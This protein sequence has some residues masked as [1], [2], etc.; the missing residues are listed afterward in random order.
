MVKP[1]QASP[2][3]FKILYT[4]QVKWC[5]KDLCSNQKGLKPNPKRSVWRTFSGQLTVM[6]VI[7][8]S[9]FSLTV[10]RENRTA[11]MSKWVNIDVVTSIAPKTPLCVLPSPSVRQKEDICSS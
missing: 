9:P 6:D 11:A 4:L 2:T 8:A 3:P 10:Q 5:Q 7:G 1:N